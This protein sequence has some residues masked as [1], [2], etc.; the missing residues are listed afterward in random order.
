[1]KRSRA[2]LGGRRFE[3]VEVVDHEQ[4]PARRHLLEGTAGGLDRGPA[5]GHPGQD[6]HEGR[7]EVLEQGRLRLVPAL[8]PVPRDRVRR[9][10]GKAG[11]QGGLARTGGRHD[12]PEAVVPDAPEA[13]VDALPGQA[14]H[15]R[16]ADL[17]R[18]DRRLRRPP[19]EG[20]PAGAGTRN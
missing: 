18:R 12:Q 8:G 7:L 5:A 17:G 10:G 15:D 4:D 1:M 14:G 16:D 11:E 2:S 20:A 9:G 19:G 3:H 6:H 13:V